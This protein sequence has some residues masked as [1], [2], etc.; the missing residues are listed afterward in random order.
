M[1]RLFIG[2]RGVGKSTLLERHREY[3][4]EVLHLDLDE[5]IQKRT[6]DAPSDYFEKFG[7]ESFRL[8]EKEV[9]LQLQSAHQRFVIAVGAGFDTELIPDDVEVIFVSR[10]T[11]KDGRIFLNRPRL[12]TAL[13]HLEEY[14]KR[15]EQRHKKF[16]NRADFVYQVPEGITGPDKI[17]ATLLQKDFQIEDA[18]YTLQARDIEKLS[19]IT[20]RYKNIE[21]RTDLLSGE[22]IHSVVKR[23]PDRALLVS[24]RNK[25]DYSLPANTR[26]DRDYL[27]FDGETHIISSHSD[28]IQTGI[29]QLK[30]LSGQYF[31]KLSPLVESFAEL[32]KGFRWQQE[33]PN[34]RSFLPRSLGGRWLW[35]RQ[36]AKYLQP[37]NF[38]KSSEVAD[39]PSLY[40]WLTLPASR[41]EAWGAVL[42]YPV[43]FSRSPAEHAE[44]FRKRKSFFCKIE[45]QPDEAAQAKSFIQ[46]LGCRYMAVTSP[47]KEIFF[48]L[49]KSRTANAAQFESANTVFV[50]TSGAVVHNT[51]AE[52]FRNLVSEIKAP[53]IAAIWGGGGTLKMMRS[54]LP[55]A[56]CYSGQTGQP[57]EATAKTTTFT[58][59]IWAAPRSHKTV[60]PS[61]SM[62]IRK[63]IDLNYTENSMGLEFAATEKIGYKSGLE[64]FKAQAAAQ[65]KF[66][67]EN[68]EISGR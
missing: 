54:V 68:E 16:I 1:R 21:L 47:L 7:E 65:Q 18:Y 46:E 31:L 41:P 60:F 4:P 52:G 15:Y 51:D 9:F 6:G 19:E 49:H 3:F 13:S 62:E 36:I 42:G 27:Y 44:F 20:K 55:T 39:Q 67:A 57:R 25:I 12:E 64:M 5:E 56:T 58:Y 61:E 43:Y 23:V 28:N 63:V 48:N 14:K 26:V 59:L 11:D 8:Q 24:V 40:E 50:G 30:E 38:I 29:H 17:E 10:V 45:V 33:D 66:W 53:E 22:Q 37:L 32:E 35:Y 34:H 2:H